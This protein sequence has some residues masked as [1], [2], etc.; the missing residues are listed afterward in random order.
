MDDNDKGLDFLLKMLE[1]QDVACSTVRDGHVLMFKMDK[2]KALV[3]Q[4][5][6]KEAITIFVKRPDFKN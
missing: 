1:T 2:L 5:K 3:E 6:D 4:H